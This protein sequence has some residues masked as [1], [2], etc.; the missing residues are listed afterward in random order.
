M[1]RSGF[2]RKIPSLEQ[3]PAPGPKLKRCAI[4]GCRKPF[5]PDRSF[6]TWCSPECGELVALER[7]AKEKAKAARADRVA[8]KRKLLELEPLEHYLK[9]AERACNAYIRARDAGQGC[10]S[11]GRHD[12]DV[13]N[14]G[15]FISV[16]ANGTL[17]FDEDNIHLQC[18]RPCNKDKGGNI[19]E[20]RKALLIKIGLERLERLENWHAP[21]KRTREDVQAIEKYFK[22]K[23]KALNS[24]C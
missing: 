22:E 2:A 14:A 8:T 6:V 9:K 19:H 10:I 17:R 11:C 16:G 12:A 1:I 5:H 24:S 23:L 21:V 4:K 7:I 3:K 18:A 13:W 15:H 20:Y